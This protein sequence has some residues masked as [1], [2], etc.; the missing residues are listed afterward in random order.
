MAAKSRH[1]AEQP[2]YVRSAGGAL[3][4]LGAVWAAG[5]YPLAPVSL[6]TF[7]QPR[8]GDKD[9]VQHLS[10]VTGYT[11]RVIHRLDVVPLLPLN[12]QGFEHYYP[13]GYLGCSTA[14]RL[15]AVLLFIKL[16]SQFYLRYAADSRWGMVTPSLV[17]GGWDHKMA[18]S[19]QRAQLDQRGVACRS[20]MHPDFLALL[21]LLA[22]GQPYRAVVVSIFC[23]LLAIVAHGPLFARLCALPCVTDHIRIMR[24]ALQSGPHSHALAAIVA[25]VYRYQR[26][27]KKAMAALGFKPIVAQ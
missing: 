6:F 24:E 13:A 21:A 22:I 15:T 20:T 16:K 1:P 18:R 5:Q 25:A 27:Y 14:E 12:R 26:C 7:G 23:G 19:A 4:T 11:A 2:L 9:F 10:M 3:A 8:V 17:V